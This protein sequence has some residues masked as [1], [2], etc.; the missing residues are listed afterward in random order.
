VADKD[1]FGKDFRERLYKA[2]KAWE[3]RHGR[4]LT[5]AQLG[6]MVG[7]YKGKAVLQS[8]VSDWRGWLVP[9]A[10][11]ITWIA[12]ALE[13]S[14]AWLAYGEGAGPDDPILRA[15]HPV[16]EPKRSGNRH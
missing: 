3:F 7:K 8:T 4:D 16:P 15:Q 5:Q 14:P 2:W 1:R 6:V 12:R 10:E 11:E 13:C 9:G